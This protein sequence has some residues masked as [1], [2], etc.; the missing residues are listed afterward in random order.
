MIQ[1]PR[2]T[3]DIF[4]I[5]SKQYNDLE[6]TIINVLKTYNLNEIRTPIFEAKEL[7]VRSVGETSDVVS[8]EMYEFFDKKGREFVLRPEGTAPIVRSLIENK[9]YAPEFLPL[10]LYYVGPMFRYERP[11][12]G[13]YRQFEQIGVE[14]LGVDSV[15]QD[16]EILAMLDSITKAIKI[17]TKVELDLN[18]LVTGKQREI[19]IKELTK[20]LVDFDDLCDDCEVR[21]HKNPLRTLDCKIDFNKFKTAPKMTSFLSKEDEA[22]FQQIL[23]AG[24]KIGLKININQRLVRGL[25]YYT[26]LIFE[27]KYLESSLGSQSTIIAGGRYNNLVKDL[28]GPDLPAIGFAMG[29]ER[30]ILILEENQINLNHDHG[31]DLYT[32]ALSPEAMILNLEIIRDLRNNNIKVETDYLNRSLKSNFKQAEKLQAKNVIV[33]G[34]NEIETQKIVIKNQINKTQTEVKISDLVEEMKA[35]K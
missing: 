5:K 2:G 4:E 1:K 20:F 14:I 28:D 15:Y 29:V 23:E 30:L 8:K 10:K 12:T 17:D 31:I 7:F 35:G 9:L 24:K 27:L 13:R 34:D 25:D 6:N 26:G 3:Q 32:I 22:R 19:Y 18:Y 16:I 21:I 11:Q 33:I